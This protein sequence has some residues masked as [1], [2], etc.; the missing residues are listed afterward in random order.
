MWRGVSNEPEGKKLIEHDMSAKIKSNEENFVII[1]PIKKIK[2]DHIGIESGTVILENTIAVPQ[3]L[4]IELVV[5]HYPAN[6]L[7]GMY[8]K[9]LKTGIQMKPYMSAFIATL[10]IMVKKWKQ[11]S[12][13]TTDR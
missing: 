9:E 5:V 6:A 13:P 2:R 1:F 8:P 10:F 3:T 7:W 4:N 11:L 12:Y